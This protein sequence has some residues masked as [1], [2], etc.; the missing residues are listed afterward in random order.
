MNNIFTMLLA[1]GRGERLHPLTEHR[2]KPA[3]PFGGKYRI[4]D[5]TLSNCLN[6]GLRKVAVLIQYKSHSLDRHIRTGWN[7]LNAELGEYIA[8][9]P[10]QQRISEEW[11]RGT[12]DAVYQNLFLLESEQPEF[13]LIL[14]G[15]HIYKMDYA[16]MFHWLVVKNADVVVG[17][18]DIPIEDVSRFGVIEVDEDFRVTEFHEKPA[19]A[20]PIPGDPSKAFGS[21]G[22]YLFR[23]QSMREELIADAQENTAHDFGKNIIPRMIHSRRVYAYKF[24]DANKK[25]EKYWRDVGTLD[26]YWEA[27]LDLVAVDPLFNLYD[28]EWPIRTYQGQF[29]P[30]KF[31]FA[32]DY[33]GGRMGVAL[34]S[35]V[36]GGCIISGGRVQTSVLSPN[37]RVQDHA[38][39]RESV[40]MENVVIGEHS[41]IRRAIIDKDVV[42]PPN[43]EIGYN[44]DADAQRFTVTESG[45]VVISKGMKLHASLDSSS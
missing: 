5:F 36:C 22:I 42:I 19:K 38:D 39:V 26:A 44:R 1:G 20:A 40:I 31:V 29:P 35:I 13:V 7:V 4:I 8:S 6:S 33:Q 45:L 10:P 27:N 15:D 12:A 28:Q 25:A 2:A 16:E 37:V 14:A 18:I 32:Q 43:T 34:D 17:A 24:Q 23:T 3:V 11:Y 9:I 41:R 30:A 21:M